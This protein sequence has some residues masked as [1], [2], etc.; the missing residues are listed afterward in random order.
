MSSVRFSPTGRDFC[1]STTEG[2]LV[3][4]LDSRTA[5]DPTELTE[6]VTPASIR[7][8]LERGEQAAGLV[9]AMR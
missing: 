5:F 4:S 3:Y 6:E 7:A 1:A 2:L 9:M 8:A